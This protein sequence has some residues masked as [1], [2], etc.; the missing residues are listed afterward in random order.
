MVLISSFI[1]KSA[2]CLF[3]SERLPCK[4]STKRQQKR[5]VKL[6]LLKDTYSLFWQHYFWHPPKGNGIDWVSY[7]QRL[8]SGINGTEISQKHWLKFLHSGHYPK[9]TWS[10]ISGE[11]W[12]YSRVSYKEFLRMNCP[13]RSADISKEVVITC[14]LPQKKRDK[15]FA[16]LNGNHCYS[17]PNLDYTFRLSSSALRWLI[18]RREGGVW[19]E[20]WER[21]PRRDKVWVVNVKDHI[22]LKSHLKTVMPCPF[23][24]LQTK[25]REKVATS[26]SRFGLWFI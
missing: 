7:Q 8:F 25:K 23:W 1:C 3:L 18:G 14:C 11:R 5:K 26:D 22:C 2:L 13:L 20:D 19:E 6:T 9:G 15:S 16:I 4:W 24:R 12:N 10:Q 21:K 17:A